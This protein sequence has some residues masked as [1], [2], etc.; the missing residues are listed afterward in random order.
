MN[1]KKIILFIVSIFLI[2]TACTKIEKISTEQITGQDNSQTDQET[3]EVFSEVSQEEL[4]EIK[5]LESRKKE[6]EG[7]KDIEIDPDDLYSSEF[8]LMDEASGQII[9]SHDMDTRTYPASLTKI[10]TAIVAIENLADPDS[11]FSISQETYDDLI[12]ADASMAGFLPGEEVG[13]EDLLYGTMMPSGADASVGLAML[14]SGGVENHVA[15]M[16]EKVKDLGLTNTH[17]ANVT[18]LHDEDNYSSAY[19]MAEITRYSLE[20]DIFRKVMTAPHHR[21]QPTEYHKDGMLLEYSV[22]AFAEEHGVDHYDIL[23]GKTGFTEE[24]GR[25]LSSLADINGHTYILVTLGA[26]QEKGHFLDAIY[27]YDI[28]YQNSNLDEDLDQAG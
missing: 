8:C 6:L 18:G 26:D 11:K 21:T 2:F 15:K 12:A 24:A 28:I 5:K 22:V 1:M 13:L 17:F 10:M 25:C 4:E 23:G 14:C 3:G 19:D 9:L 7:L 20:N 16:N 27:L